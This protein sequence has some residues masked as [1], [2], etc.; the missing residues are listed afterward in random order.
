MESLGKRYPF[1]AVVF[2]FLSFL[3]WMRVRNQ[4]QSMILNR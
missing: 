1:L 4:Y 2:H 3:W